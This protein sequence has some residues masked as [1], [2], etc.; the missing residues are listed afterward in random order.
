MHACARNI[1]T[2]TKNYLTQPLLIQQL[3]Q[4]ASNLLPQAV[5][6][7]NQHGHP[8]TT[9]S[10]EVL[11]CQDASLQC[12]A[13]LLTLWLKLE[14][15]AVQVQKLWCLV[16]VQ[17]KA[18]AKVV[19]LIQLVDCRLRVKIVLLWECWWKRLQ[20]NNKTIRNH[21]CEQSHPTIWGDLRMCK[22]KAYMLKIY[23]VRKSTCQSFDCSNSSLLF[24]SK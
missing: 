22:W 23:S 5:L 4:I 10:C 15:L 1:L 12:F 16:S 6:T 14:P 24:T 17:S 2:E 8:G 7:G 20:H 19:H 21:V 9:F 3:W 13:A 11:P 18:I